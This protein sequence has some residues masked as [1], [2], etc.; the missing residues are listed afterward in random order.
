MFFIIREM[1]YDKI[2]LKWSALV[3]PRRGARELR[4]GENQ[5]PSPRVTGWVVGLP[6]PPGRHAA[7][8]GSGAAWPGVAPRALFLEAES[9]Q[10]GL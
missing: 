6:T 8:R 5:P 4:P 1:G 7:S 10:D 2:T 9:Y 3:V